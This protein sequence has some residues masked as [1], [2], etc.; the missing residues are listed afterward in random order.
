MKAILLFLFVTLS[1][2]SHG[3]KDIDVVYLKSGVRYVC[4]IQ[5]VR[6]DSIYF[7]QF[8]GRNLIEHAYPMDQ[9]SFYLVN[10]FYSTPG[11]EMMKVSRRMVFGTVFFTIG[12]TMAYLGYK[13]KRR[14]LMDLGMGVAAVSSIFW[15]SGTAKMLTVGRKMEKLTFE[16]DRLIFKL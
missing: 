7:T 5:H 10:N 6:N 2:L 3:Q 8:R 1:L 13:D 11:E 4:E 12:G 16:G 15:I 9:T 14:N